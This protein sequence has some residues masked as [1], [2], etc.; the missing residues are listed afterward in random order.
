MK[1]VPGAVALALGGAIGMGF[2]APIKR[3]VLRKGQQLFTEPEF[4]L[5][6]FLMTLV[7]SV[8]FLV[9]LWALFGGQIQVNNPTIFYGAMFFWFVANVGV[10]VSNLFAARHADVSL[11]LPYQAMTPG[12]LTVAVFL[13]GERPSTLGYVGIITIA[14]GA[15]IHGR[16]GAA[17]TIWEWF[18]PLWRLLFLPRNYNQ[19]DFAAQQKVRDEQKGVRLAGLSALCGTFGLLGEALMARHGNPALGLSGGLVLL[20][21]FSVIWYLMQKTSPTS[22]VPLKKRLALHRKWFVFSSLAMCVACFLPM[23]AN[24]LA[25][26]AYV[27]TMKRFAIPIGVFISAK[28]FREKVPFGRW[29]TATIITAGAVMLVLDDTH[30]KV[31]DFMD[32][33]LVTKP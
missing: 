24:R 10:N 15:Y 25:P 29:I 23:I 14:I 21:G 2:G 26:I 16:L 33:F 17:K 7:F 12:I 13:I 28:W 27:G 32:K 18:V 3:Q 5:G 6:Q 30:A 1:M 4:M 22:M 31:F 9:P 20:T 8:I 11:T 19:M